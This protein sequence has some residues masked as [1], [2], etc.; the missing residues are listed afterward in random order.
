MQPCVAAR[1][2]G[3]TR[4]TC[5]N[6]LHA[7]KQ[8]EDDVYGK[9]HSTMSPLEGWTHQQAQVALPDLYV[10]ICKQYSHIAEQTVS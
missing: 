3:D 5:G 10:P 6:I 1:Q 7:P 8:R 9:L 4:D 2:S